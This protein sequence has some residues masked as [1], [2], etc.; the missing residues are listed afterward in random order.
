MDRAA[1]YRL[2]TAA[3]CLPAT[4]RNRN[5]QRGVKM[6][7]LLVSP[8]LPSTLRSSLALS[9]CFPIPHR[10]LARSFPW[11]NDPARR[12]T[13]ACFALAESDFAKSG[14]GDS[15]GDGKGGGDDEDL[16]PLLRDLA[17]TNNFPF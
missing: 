14:S 6:A 7:S 1:D 8:P 13:V 17:V 9:S 15:G 10:V 11:R 12:G 16:L 3:A 5:R 4:H 2:T